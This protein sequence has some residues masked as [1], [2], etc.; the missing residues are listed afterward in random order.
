MTNVFVIL[1]FVVLI[2]NFVAIFEFDDRFVVKYV[3]PY[4][5][6]YGL[7]TGN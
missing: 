1:C 6:A 3:V 7:L 2:I 5:V 4:I